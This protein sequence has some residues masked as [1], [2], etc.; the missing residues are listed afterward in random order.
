[1]ILL[2]V[3]RCQKPAKVQL[4]SQICNTLPF[5]LSAPFKHASRAFH[6]LLKRYY[7][8]NTKSSKIQI[9]FRFFAEKA[10]FAFL[11]CNSLMFNAEK[12][13]FF[14][15]FPAFFPKLY[16]PAIRHL[17]LGI[18]APQIADVPH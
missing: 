2:F 10:H 17:N 14:R 1:V 3:K 13:S 4:F 15:H 8:D 5:V 16:L 7:K 6:V 12:S 9:Y 18:M 11:A